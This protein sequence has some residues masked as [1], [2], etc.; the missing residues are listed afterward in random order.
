MII[1]PYGAVIN[2]T[3]RQFQRMEIRVVRHFRIVRIC[4]EHFRITLHEPRLRQ[5]I[6]VSDGLRGRVPLFQLVEVQHGVGHYLANGGV[7]RLR[8]GLAH[9]LQRRKIPSHNVD[10]QGLAELLTYGKT[11]V[12]VR[13]LG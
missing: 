6:R 7:I 10:A 2:T 9:G 1:R 5:R 11:F 4:R 3:Q 13:K 12:V 8:K